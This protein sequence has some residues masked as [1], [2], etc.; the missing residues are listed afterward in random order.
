M[1]FSH[2][3][4][5]YTLPTGRQTGM[6]RESRAVS[7]ARRKYTRGEG[8]ELTYAYKKNRHNRFWA[9]YHIFLSGRF[10]G[11]VLLYVVL[12]F[13]IFLILSSGQYNSISVL[14]LKARLYAFRCFKNGFFSVGLGS[15]Q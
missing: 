1:V 5:G 14:Y 4:R 3:A 13:L 8:C 2:P 15:L 9:V 10:L 11:N 7:Y 6:R 12:V